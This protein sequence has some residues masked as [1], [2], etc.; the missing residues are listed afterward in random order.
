MLESHSHAQNR[1]QRTGGNDSIGPLV[2]SDKFV[3]NLNSRAAGLHSSLAAT[4]AGLE[5]KCSAE[6]QIQR[7]GQDTSTTPLALVI[8]HIL[9][10]T[11][12]AVSEFAVSKEILR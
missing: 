2:A 5:G 6:N 8:E 9:C 7:G 3:S 4:L 11:K 12:Q 1:S 10:L